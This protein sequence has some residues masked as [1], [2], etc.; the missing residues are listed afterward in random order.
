MVPRV[1][2]ELISRF[3]KLCPTCKVRRGQNRT[4]PPES[5]KSPEEYEHSPEMCS[6]V[7]RRDS[8]ATKCSSVSVQSPLQIQGSSSLFAHQNRWMTSAQPSDVKMSDNYHTTSPNSYLAQDAMSPSTMTPSGSSMARSDY[9]LSFSS[10][11]GSNMYPSTS[12][13]PSSNVRLT[14]NWQRAPPGYEVKQETHY[15]GDIKY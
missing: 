1:P 14:N 10:V 4:S 9:N 15:D 7:S 2:K 12:G 13:F 6:P 3:V 5:E 11:N 8:M